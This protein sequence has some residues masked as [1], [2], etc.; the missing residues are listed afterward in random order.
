MVR[1]EIK[2]GYGTFQHGGCALWKGRVH[3]DVAPT[4]PIPDLD[5]ARRKERRQQNQLPLRH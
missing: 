2:E 3:G 1:L 5:E 4:E